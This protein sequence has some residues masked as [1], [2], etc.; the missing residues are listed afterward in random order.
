MATIS[1]K[2]SPTHPTLLLTKAD[3]EKRIQEF[4]QDRGIEA[5]LAKNH[6]LHYF[7][8][9]SPRGGTLRDLLQSTGYTTSSSDIHCDQCTEEESCKFLHP[10]VADAVL[11]GSY[12]CGCCYR[13]KI[14]GSQ[15]GGCTIMGMSQG[16]LQ[17]LREFVPFWS[18]VPCHECWSSGS[19][20]NNSPGSCNNC[21]DSDISCQREACVFFKE[22]RDDSF[23]RNCDMAHHDDGY[24][25]VVTTSRGKGY[26]GEEA[27]RQ[28]LGH[29]SKY[30]ERHGDQEGD[31]RVAICNECW[32]HNRD[33]LCTNETDCAPCQ[34]RGK[35]GESISCR[36]IKCDNFASCS[37]KRCTLAHASHRIPTELLDDYVRKRPRRRQGKETNPVYM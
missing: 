31:G 18:H 14:A 34:I 30:E 12:C 16:T 1:L 22:P 2:Y 6:A 27:A 3:L 4:A 36:R 33:D 29:G 17:S 11:D 10:F 21:R 9:K 32:A 23:C 19:R 8:E 24:E 15:T 35:N 20:C 7:I 37:S 5:R 25:N 26:N 28:C 13:R